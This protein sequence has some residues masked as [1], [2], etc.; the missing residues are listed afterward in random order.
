M[1]YAEKVK[2][3]RG[4]I[5]IN[6]GR[7]RYSSFANCQWHAHATSHASIVLSGRYREMGDQ[8]RHPVEA[9]SVLLHSRFDAH[10]NDFEAGTCELLNLPLPDDWSSSSIG[11]VADPDMLARTAERDVWEAASLLMESFVALGE[12]SLAD[13][14]DYLAADLRANDHLE[15]GTWAH[16]TGLAFATVSRGFKAAFGMSP[17]RYRRRQRALRAWRYLLANDEPLAEA[18]LACGFC[19]Q[20]YMT[21]EVLWLTGKTPGEWR[22]ERQS[23]TR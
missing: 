15:I 18:A 13:W 8:G 4:N 16:Q 10:R 17:A 6:H 11:T 9:G 22:A 14:P 5:E 20:A 3:L 1:A 12:H 7:K 21:H 19:D 23:S 2:D